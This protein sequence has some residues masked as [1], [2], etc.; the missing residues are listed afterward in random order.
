VHARTLRWR[1]TSG[2][3]RCSDRLRVETSP[4]AGGWSHRPG[5][6]RRAL[7]GFMDLVRSRDEEAC[8]SAPGGCGAGGVGPPIRPSMVPLAPLPF[9]PDPTDQRQAA[10]WLLVD[11]GL[12]LEDAPGGS[13][14]TA[15]GRRVP[16]LAV[17]PPSCRR[18]CSRSPGRRR[19]GWDRGRGRCRWRRCAALE[20]ASSRTPGQ[21]S[22]PPSVGP[23]RPAP[24]RRHQPCP[25]AAPASRGPGRRSRFRR[26]LG[27]MVQIA[28]S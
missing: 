17:R 8:S 13:A 1:R 15:T 4:P 25:P 28:G 2:P 14:R 27:W 9:R 12:S 5:A 19:R 26:I 10:A 24:R 20:A 3:G 16:R 23:G 21:V 18:R 7:R 11:L 22:V 6:W